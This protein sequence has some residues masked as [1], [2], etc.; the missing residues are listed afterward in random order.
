MLGCAG[1]GKTT[2]ARRIGAR[3]GAPVVVLDEI[4]PPERGPLDLAWF[5]QRLREAHAGEAWVSDGNFALA[6]FDLRLP[7]AELIVWLEAPAWLCMLRAARRVFRSGEAHRLGGLAKVMA[8]IRGFDRLNRPRIEAERLVHGPQVPVVHLVG[9][10]ASRA[11]LE[12]LGQGLDL[13]G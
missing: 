7:R 9:A 11:F 4:W 8:F 2:L 10:K 12:S 13:A 1:T 6:S 3:I 5:R